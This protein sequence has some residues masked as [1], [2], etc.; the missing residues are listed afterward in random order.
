[1]LLAGLAACSSPSETP[2]ANGQ[3]TPNVAGPDGATALPD[4]CALLTTA[5][6]NAATGH[7]FPDGAINTTVTQDHLA[8]CDWTASG[9][10]TVQVLVSDVQLFDSSRTTAD[11]IYG[12]IDV[13]VPGMPRAYAVK[14]GFLIGMDAPGF[15]LQV[16][17]ITVDPNVATITSQLAANVAQHVG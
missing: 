12:V 7:T 14:D 15:F 10:G 1:M 13:T 17:Y 9:A 2:D 8:A 4:P 3:T 16:S 6:V 11:Q 5:E